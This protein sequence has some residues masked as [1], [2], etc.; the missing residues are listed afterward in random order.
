MVSDATSA[1][2]HVDNQFQTSNCILLYMSLCSVSKSDKL[3]IELYLIDKNIHETVYNNIVT[4]Y[5]CNHKMAIL[6][7]SRSILL[8]NRATPQQIDEGLTMNNSIKGF[9]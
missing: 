6:V 1:F 8:G 3:F 7:V 9:F 5:G 4:E 2:H